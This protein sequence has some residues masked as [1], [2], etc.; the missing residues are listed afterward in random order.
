MINEQLLEYIKQQLAA[1]LSR[2]DIAKTLISS[3]WQIADINEV[4]AVAQIPSQSSPSSVTVSN[5]NGD[6]RLISVGQLIT[7]SWDLYKKYLSTS[8][9]IS[10][11]ASLLVGRIFFFEMLGNPLAEILFLLAILPPIC[12]S[13]I[14]LVYAVARGGSFMESYRIGFSL[15]FPFL[16]I[17]IIYYFIFLGGTL[18]FIIPAIL[19]S[20][21]FLL[22]WYTFI[23][24][25]KR[26]LNVLLQS[27][28]YV[29][30]YWWA[31]FGRYLLLFTIVVI[32]TLVTFPMAR[33]FGQTIAD[34]SY[35]IIVW[36]IAPFAIGYMYNIYQSLAKLK[37]SLATINPTRGRGFLITCAITGFL[38]IV[39]IAVLYFVLT[40]FSTTNLPPESTNSGT[41]P[42][43]MIVA[44]ESIIQSGGRINVLSIE[45]N[46][47]D[48]PLWIARFEVPEGVGVGLQAVSFLGQGVGPSIDPNMDIVLG[49]G[50]YAGYPTVM[51]FGMRTYNNTNSDQVVNIISKTLDSSGAILNQST[52]PI[53]IQ[54]NVDNPIYSLLDKIRPQSSEYEY[55]HAQGGFTGFCTSPD[56][57]SMGG[58]LDILIQLRKLS[59]TVVCKDSQK[60]WAISVQTKSDPKKYFC[61]DGPETIVTRGTTITTTSCK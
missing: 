39:A 35:L 61:V 58:I 27:W 34:I 30:G 12:I 56:P 60:A 52:L 31:V 45:K 43:Q 33:L 17:G 36:L 28:E 20:V 6:Q 8:L 22:F 11:V 10:L 9:L 47:V 54:F 14:A 41:A 42:N 3:G 5:L 23:L 37:P 13:L 55:I 29:R 15:F 51:L 40:P 25:G 2:D 46:P 19:M 4:F 26:G 50:L 48:A 53:T 1:G 59:G 21:W 57:A 44:K 24:E 18:M 38:F 16:W 7:D 32:S 49:T